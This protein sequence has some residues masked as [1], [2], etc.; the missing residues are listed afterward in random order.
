LRIDEIRNYKDKKAIHQMHYEK[1]I[2]EQIEEKYRPIWKTYFRDQEIWEEINKDVRRTRSE[3][4]Y[5]EK[6]LIPQKITKKDI[7]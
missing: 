3:T 7:E 4:G 5:F 2:F 6:P 1:E